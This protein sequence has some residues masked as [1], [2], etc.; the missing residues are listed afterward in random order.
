MV[1][2]TR[3]N[4]KLFKHV[5]RIKPHNSDVTSDEM[6]V[7]KSKKHPKIP[8]VVSRRPELR[9]VGSNLL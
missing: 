5:S 3:Y 8:Q 6:E 9:Q 2:Y 4:L 1:L 7:K